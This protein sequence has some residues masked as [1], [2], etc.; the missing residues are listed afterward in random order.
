[1]TEGFTHTCSLLHAVVGSLG[2]S[3][4]EIIGK[5]KEYVH[6]IVAS[7][8]M[9]KICGQICVVVCKFHRFIMLRT[10]SAVFHL[11]GLVS[12]RQWRRWA[13]PDSMGKH[14]DLCST[15]AKLDSLDAEGHWGALW[16]GR[17]FVWP[18]H[19]VPGPAVWWLANLY[20]WHRESAIL[21]YNQSWLV[22]NLNVSFR[23][24]KTGVAC[25]WRLVYHN[26]SCWVF[27]TSH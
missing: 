17:S 2:V 21:T 7:P 25:V 12:A 8:G 3:V 24:L 19:T 20:K 1:M 11:H 22:T 26:G 18:G 14:G 9:S 5:D 23:F 27:H 16:E 10:C 4:I 15:A 6:R 13:S